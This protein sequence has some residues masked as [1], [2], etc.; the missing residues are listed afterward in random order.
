MRWHS[1]HGDIKVI[2]FKENVTSYIMATFQQLSIIKSHGYSVYNIR[3]T[4]HCIESELLESSAEVVLS[5]SESLVDI[6]LNYKNLNV[7]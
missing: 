2:V 3:L 1:G 4:L 5:V 6:S 7:F